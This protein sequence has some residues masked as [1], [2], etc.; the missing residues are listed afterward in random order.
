MNKH[1]GRNVDDYL[2]ERGI[3][4]EVEALTQ[5][6]LETLRAEEPLKPGEAYKITEEPTGRITKFF[7]WLRHA[8]NL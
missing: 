7:H 4:E 6:E 5:K 1:R 8:M 3:F 2:K